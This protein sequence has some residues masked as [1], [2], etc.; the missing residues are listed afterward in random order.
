MERVLDDMQW[1]TALVSIDDVIIFGS[2]FEEKLERLEEVLQW[3]R[4]A[5]L[6][7]S[8]K[9]CSL[10]QHEDFASVAAPLHRLTRKGACFVWDE[11][12][13]AA[14]DGLKK[15]LVEAPVLPYPDPKL[16]YLLDTDASAEGIW[17]V[18]SQVKDGTEHV[19]AYYSATFSWPERSYCVT[20]KELVAVVKSLE[21]F[22]PYLY[23]AEFTIRTDHAALQWL[24]MLKVP[25]GRLARCWQASQRGTT[26]GVRHSVAVAVA[27][28][29]PTKCLVDQWATLQVDERGVTSGHLGEKKTLCRLRQ[30][31]YWVGMRSDVIEWCR[32][33][34]VCSGKKGPT[35]KNRAP[36][37]VY[38]VGAPMERVAVDIAGLL[39]LTPRG[40]WYICVVMDY[41]TKW[42]EAYALPNH[43]AETVAGVLVNEFFTRFGVPAE[44][45]SDQGRKFE[46]Q[47]F[48]ECCELLGTRKIQTTPLHPQSDGMVE[49]FNRTL[50]QQL[51]KYCEEDQG[52][53]DV[54]LP[55]MLMAYRSAVHE[56]TGF[57]PAHLM[58]GPA[59]QEH[60]VEV[61]RRA[62]G[63]LKV[64]GLA[65]KETYDR[66][67]RNRELSPK[68][69][70]PWKGPYTVEA[71]LSDVTNLIRRGRKRPS[72]V[73]D[74][75]R[76]HGPGRYSWGHGGEDEDVSPSS[77]D[78]DVAGAA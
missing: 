59:L 62:R 46:S 27:P 58:F 25:E 18:L 14:F 20:R 37:Q 42:P 54:K 75:W 41:F 51:A 35:R 7:L 74:L 71:V 39:P 30:R 38:S 16:P 48:R 12:C 33:C 73:H 8:P 77:S 56:V 13:Q 2:T 67:M 32:A 55:A 28:E 1:K 10:F 66:R 52:D 36:L 26:S 11:A 70:S 64:A 69:Q 40:N 22:H 50:A 45:H 43:E 47:M 29:S 31:F 72:V 76:Y 78:E 21:H 23:G 61:H 60:L 49:R 3:L 24:K 19:V 65:M 68:L 6:K 5:N 57:T 15:A 4:K 17:A 53:W 63:K 9:N 44:L 34:D